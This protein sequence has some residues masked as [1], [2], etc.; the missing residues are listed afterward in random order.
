MNNN[1]ESIMNNTDI[2][3]S[4]NT[5]K[6][7]IS[8]HKIVGRQRVAERRKRQ[9]EMRLQGYKPKQIFAKL[10]EEYGVAIH[11]L[12]VDWSERQ[13]W[14]LSA[15]SLTD[16][17]ETVGASIGAFNASQAARRDILGDIVGSIDAF[18]E[19]HEDTTGRLD[20]SATE[21]L[22]GL[23]S[24]VL[25]LLNDTEASAEKKIAMLTKLG[26]LKKAAQHLIIEHKGEDKSVKGVDWVHVVGGM[27]EDSR[28]EFFDSLA[29]QR[30][31]V[32]D[33]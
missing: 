7:D 13:D 4:C 12:E 27:S 26:V 9:L 30:E 21:A 1:N 17:V 22:Q 32:I 20:V 31:A 25:R 24:T 3:E 23:Y 6:D 19:D 2:E 29:A 5:N 10:S 15:I 8:Q 14:I 33:V 16:M 11:T 28:R 18:R